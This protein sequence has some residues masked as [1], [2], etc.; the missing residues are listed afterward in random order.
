MDWTRAAALLYG[1]WGTSKAYVTGFAFSG[2]VGA[3]AYKSLP[4]IV[5]V[6]AL[7]ALVAYNYII[8][9][10]HYPDG[11]GVYSAARLQSRFLAV[12][13][14]LLLV[15]NF[16]VTAA[17]SGWFGMGYLR[18]PQ[19]FIGLATMGLILGIGIV[20]YFGPK[21]SGSFAVI[22]LVPMVAVVILIV[23]LSLLTGPGLSF[24]NL[25]P[26]PKDFRANWIAFVNLILALSGVEAIANLTGVMKLDPGATMEKPRVV[27]T[28]SKAIG[29]VAVEVVF[30][31]AL[32]G[33]AMLSLPG[34]GQG[35][36]SLL[37]ERWEDM[38]SVLAEQYGALA[39][40]PVAGRVFGVLTGIIVGLLLLSA[41]NT[42]VAAL[43]GLA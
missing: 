9:C 30:G 38:L 1:D 41:V 3:A 35:L 27:R 2:L 19:A 10:K 18:V 14:A 13:G 37:H 5:A 24:A 32:C 25:E 21:H 26:P 29:L 34:K 31:T 22:L 7:T 33:W 28:A 17:M 42:A 4:I 20:N 16:T 15:A 8:V 40:S 6:C 23:G 43:I 39:W 36:E 12:L 11:G